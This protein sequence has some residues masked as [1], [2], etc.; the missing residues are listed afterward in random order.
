[1]DQQPVGTIL[2]HLLKTYDEAINELRGEVAELRQEVHRA[3][4]QAPAPRR[5]TLR[6]RDVCARSGLSQATIY[7][8]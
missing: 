3:R 5:A 2:D 4:P 6:I 8:L 7:R 1:M